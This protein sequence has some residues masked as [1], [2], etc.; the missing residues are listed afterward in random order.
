MIRQPWRLCGEP[1]LNP[2]TS[3]DGCGLLRNNILTFRI[4][5]P[6]CRNFCPTIR[7]LRA[8]VA[9]HHFFLSLLH[10]HSLRHSASFLL[11][12]HESNCALQAEVIGTTSRGGTHR[13][14]SRAKQGAILTAVLRQLHLATLSINLNFWC[15]IEVH[16]L[17]APNP[18]PTI[19]PATPG[20]MTSI[21]SIHDPVPF[22]CSRERPP[23]GGLP[24][25]RV[26]KASSR[27]SQQ[28]ISV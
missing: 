28:D 10:T 15:V 19:S 26:C 12:L 9:W 22:H 24:V 25:N 18:S 6:S 3:L 1:L 8:V 11:L 23:H 21:D 4:F 2:P 5:P 27:A 13:L 16:L 20:F 17:S 7:R 14:A